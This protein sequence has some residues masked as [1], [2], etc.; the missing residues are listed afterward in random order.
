MTLYRETPCEKHGHME[1]HYTCEMIG[2]PEHNQMS[3]QMRTVI[4]LV[5]LVRS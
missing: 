5:V 1:S 3:P 2:Y 4:V